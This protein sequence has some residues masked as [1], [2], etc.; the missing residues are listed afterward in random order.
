M[1]FSYLA[2]ACMLATV[3]HQFAL[4]FTCEILRA[5]HLLFVVST[6]TLFRCAHQAQV[7]SS[8]MAAL[9]T[10]VFATGQKLLTGIAASFYHLAAIAG[11]ALGEN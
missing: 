5:G 6:A 1:F 9:R 8:T 7:A 4:R 2:V 10:G 3:A 11:F